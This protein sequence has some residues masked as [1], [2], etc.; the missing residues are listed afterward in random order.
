VVD[1]K[2]VHDM[3]L[4]VEQ[5]GSGAVELQLGGTST[6]I[7]VPGA[8]LCVL[9]TLKAHERGFEMRVSGANAVG[10]FVSLTV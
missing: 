8:A 6:V 7:D 4:F 3:R 5:D 1:D 9:A 10:T 2:E